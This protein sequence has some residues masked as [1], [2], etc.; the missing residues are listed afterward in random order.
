MK[1]L[2][3]VAMIKFYSELNL[4]DI[5][6]RIV[7]ED[8]F[9]T[10]YE[11]APEM[12]G[13]N[14]LQDKILTGGVKRHKKKDE[15]STKSFRNQ[16]LLQIMNKQSVKIFKNGTIVFS[17]FN[18]LESMELMKPKLVSL[19]YGNEFIEETKS[20]PITICSINGIIYNNKFTVKDISNLVLQFQNELKLDV[21][22]CGKTIRVNFL[23]NSTNPYNDGLLCIELSDTRP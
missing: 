7:I 3:T 14:I 5:V 10:Y 12:F 17:G 21:V 22:Q 16:I 13:S 4:S 2:S 15:H 23:I 11:H 8:T 20:V 1:I 19:I 9:I 18:S 6:S